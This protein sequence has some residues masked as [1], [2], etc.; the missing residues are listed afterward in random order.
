MKDKP[1]IGVPSKPNPSK[2]VGF[3]QTEMAAH[4]AWARLT[5]DKPRA[6][7]LMHLL[8]S[9]MDRTTNAVVASH[10]TLAKLMGSSGRSIKNWLLFLEDGRWIQS[11][12]LGP[13]SVNAY[14]VNSTVAWSR[15]RENLQFAEFTAQVI[16]NVDDQKPE[17]LS[18]DFDLRRIPTLYPGEMQ[19]PAGKGE[20]PPAQGLMDGLEPDLPAVQAD[21]DD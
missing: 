17:A 9:R 21:Q 19:L 10:K 6:A 14:V 15:N 20:E 5:L 18:S 12:S 4:E 3:V 13:G 1:K 11:V 2:R 16:A 8:V 7:A